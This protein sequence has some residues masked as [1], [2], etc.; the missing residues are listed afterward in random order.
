MKSRINDSI[1][2]G[3]LLIIISLVVIIA[4]AQEFEPLRKTEKD[5]E[6]VKR[7]HVGFMVSFGTRSST[8]SSNYAA[9]DGM[10][11]LEEGGSAGIIWGSRAFETE[12]TLGYYYSAARVAHTTDL[13]EV[14][15][16]TRFY[17]L[18]AIKKGSSRVNPFLSA[19]VT[20][21][22]YKLYGYYTT[23]EITQINCSVSKEPYLGNL[24]VYNASVGAGVSVSLLNDY[25][26]LKL[27]AS[28]NYS[29]PFSTQSSTDFRQT[30]MSDLW[31]FNLGVSFGVN[32]FKNN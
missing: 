19:G 16:S 5:V 1:A 9:I 11:V 26:F 8:L 29:R 6:Q 7:D 27:F 22:Y 28:T 10:N 18:R 20:K 32:R 14:R 23:E 25:D 12:I 31:S 13:I 4:Q 15:S 17:P 24:N 3:V 2:R 30:T 21:N